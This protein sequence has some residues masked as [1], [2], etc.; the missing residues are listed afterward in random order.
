MHAVPYR[1][2]DGTHPPLLSRFGEDIRYRAVIGMANDYLSYIIP[3]PDFNQNV[4]LLGGEDGDHYEDT[5][6]PASNFA[7]RVLEAQQA[8]DDRW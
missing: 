8:I 6:S 5:V 3:E 1:I 2:S 4:S 7:T